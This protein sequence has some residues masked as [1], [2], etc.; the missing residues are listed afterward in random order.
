MTILAR[1]RR[2]GLV[3][4]V[5]MV[6]FNVVEYIIDARARARGHECI[7]A[8]SQDGRYRAQSCVTGGNGSVEYYVGR[9]YDAH[10]GRLLARTDF[11]SMDGGEPL[12]IPDGNGVF[13]RGG[14]EGAIHFPPSWRDKL[15]AV[16][17]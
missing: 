6:G 10:S 11:E 15:R 16:I 14:A 4:V 7:D 9:L 2:V 12:F 8:T 17:P 3:I 5:V 1:I 13:F